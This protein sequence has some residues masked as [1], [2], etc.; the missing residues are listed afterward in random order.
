MTNDGTTAHL[1]TD[2]G[3]SIAYRTLGDG[4]RDV[5]FIHG[6][7]GSGT[8]T[9]WN[10]MIEHLD[11]T[12]LRLIMADLRGH[13]ASG[14]ATGG[15]TTE[16]FAA[17]MFAVADD[18][19]AEQVV[20]VAYSMS[21]RWAQWMACAQPERVHGQVL[22]AAVPAADIPLS[23]EVK[24][25]WLHVARDRSMATFE[26]WLRQFTREPLS[27]A[28]TQEYFETVIATPE[29]SLAE[30]LD[31]CRQHGQFMDRLQTISAPTLVVGGT[32][33][34]MLPPPVLRQAV[35]GVLPRARLATLDCGHEIP[36]EKPAELAGLMTAF[37][38][39]LGA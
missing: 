5:L 17:D 22:V 32:H 9:F 14:A 21:G 37:L 12:G 33:D 6:W 25:S 19:G 3:A 18:A 15:F 1:R 16:R 8:G 11:L 38:A 23:D 35:V 4:P 27:P 36:L 10:R 26:P 29:R 30:T 31:M 28:I 39:G 13:G 2:D 34:P 24:D 20:V 7:G